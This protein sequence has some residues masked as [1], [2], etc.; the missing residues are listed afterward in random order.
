MKGIMV[1]VGAVIKDEA[2]R[3]LLVRHVP[4]KRGFWEGKWICPGGRL[5][6][7]ESI[8]EGIHREVQEETGLEIE[9]VSPLLPFETIVKK[10]EE[11]ELH[12]IYLDYIARLKG[13]VLRPDSDVGEARWV[14]RREL[15][16]MWAQLHQDT[17]RLLLQ[18]GY[19]GGTL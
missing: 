3:V 16:G 11:V 13:G 4:E 17:R 7:G 2:D 10:G 6:V 12:V 15:P 18:A 14:S 8:A 5:E 1:A 19:P 9:L